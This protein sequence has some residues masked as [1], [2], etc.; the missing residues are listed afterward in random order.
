MNGELADDL[1]MDAIEEVGTYIRDLL[2]ATCDLGQTS[3]T[4]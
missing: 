2:I 1:N 3:T 4:E